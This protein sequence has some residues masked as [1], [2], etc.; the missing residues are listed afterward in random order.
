MLKAMPPLFQIPARSLAGFSGAS[1]PRQTRKKDLATH[2]RKKLTM[3][4]LRIAGE[5]WL[6]QRRKVRGWCRNWAGFLSVVHKVT[7]SRNQLTT[8]NKLLVSSFVQRVI[9]LKPNIASSIPIYTYWFSSSLTD[10]A[11][12]HSLTLHSHTPVSVA[13]VESCSKEGK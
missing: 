7:R 8:T 1:R 10:I 13:T 12:T 2:F 9:H 11:C 5:H 6:I 4:T 3:K